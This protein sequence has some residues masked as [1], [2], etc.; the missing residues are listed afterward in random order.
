MLDVL[1]NYNWPG[2]VRELENTIERSVVMASGNLIAMEDLPSMIRTYGS[3][4]VQLSGSTKLDLSG[5]LEQILAR[6]EEKVIRR[7]YEES[8]G[9]ISEVARRLSIGRATIYRKAEK[10]KLPIKE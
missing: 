5:T 3:D 2:N 9:N 6:I 4:M 1:L 10:Y 8:N 7:A